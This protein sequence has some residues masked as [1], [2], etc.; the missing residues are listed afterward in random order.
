MEYNDEELCVQSLKKVEKQIFSLNIFSSNSDEFKQRIKEG[1]HSQSALKCKKKK[2]NKKR[3]KIIIIARNR[4]K[5]EIDKRSKS[6]KKKKN[7]TKDKVEMHINRFSTLKLKRD[8]SESNS[9]IKSLTIKQISL[10]PVIP[11]KQQM[12]QCKK[13]TQL[14]PIQEVLKKEFT[15]L[16]TIHQSRFN[17]KEKEKEKDKTHSQSVIPINKSIIIKDSPPQK[18]DNS[19]DQRNLSSNCAYSLSSLKRK[20]NGLER[21]NIFQLREEQGER[22]SQVRKEFSDKKFIQANCYTV[23]ISIHNCCIVHH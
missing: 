5:Q 21:K 9:L 12:V 2:K 1:R 7:Q 20:F 17:N 19:I 16:S 10:K 18:I 14:I 22:I 11:V 15:N 13:K 4:S 6:A 23:I 3:K 8:S